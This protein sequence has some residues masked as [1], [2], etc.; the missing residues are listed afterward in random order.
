MAI[1]VDFG[2]AT[3]AEVCAEIGARLRAQRL[4]QRL[5]QQELAARAGVNVG[6]VKNL[7]KKI[8][9][10]SLESI[11]RVALVLGLA[12]HLQPLFALQVKSIAQM[13][14]AEHAKRLRAPSRKAR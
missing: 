13:E 6:T 5:T 2:L 14:Q 12:D 3:Y 9:T 1:M 8:M 11:V 4:A 7:E 10:A